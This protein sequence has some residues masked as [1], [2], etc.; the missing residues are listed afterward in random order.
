MGLLFRLGL[1]IAAL[2]AGLQGACAPCVLHAPGAAVPEWRQ[3]DGGAAADGYR[4]ME[5]RPPLRLLWQ[6]D[7][8]AAP[9]G[10]PLVYGAVVAQASTR[11]SVH[12]FERLS[13]GRLGR[14][15]LEAQLLGGP[16][17]AAGALLLPGGGSR[18][19]LRALDIRSR[20]QR[21]SRPGRYCGV[22]AATEDTLI[23]VGEAGT[24]AALAAA[25]GHD[26]WRFDSGDRMRVN[27]TALGT[28]V[29][30][31]TSAG[32]VLRLELA[33]GEVMWERQLDSSVRV[34]PLARGA[35]VYV[36]TR[37]GR[38]AALN[39]ATGTLEWEQVLGAIPAPALALA[40]TV[41]VAAAAD[42]RLYGLVARTGAVRWE[43]ATG[44][45]VGSPP[46]VAGSTA[47]CASSDGRLYA[48]RAADGEVLWQIDLDAP[49]MQPLAVGPG[50]VAVTTEKGTL[51]VFGADR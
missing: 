48:V 7:L 5:L 29:Y 20:V 32:R 16:A 25:D 13:G 50:F 8:G 19:A 17:L 28:A 2:L 23:A 24:V 39:A 11:P 15:G 47:F 6:A 43:Q 51:Y 3:P 21:W 37:S 1:L 30:I 35:R 33:S 18:P 36:G 45:V 27:A 42:R 9:A 44:G 41:L 49:V 40:D 12:A 46:V 4:A 14:C 31:G 22:L 38:I 10:G 34:R 26:L